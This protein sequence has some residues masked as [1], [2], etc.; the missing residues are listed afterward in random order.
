[1]IGIKN[2]GV[3]SV[4]LI[5][6]TVFFFSSMIIQKTIDETLV[7]HQSHWIVI[8]IPIKETKLETTNKKRF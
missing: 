8:S 6:S 1:M 4:L 5:F 3:P 2:P 7:V